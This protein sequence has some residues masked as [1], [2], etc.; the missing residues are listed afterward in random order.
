[1]SSRNCITNTRATKVSWHLVL[2][3]QVTTSWF[4][5]TNKIITC[6]TTNWRYCKSYEH[7]RRRHHSFSTDRKQQGVYR[8]HFDFVTSIGTGL[9]SATLLYVRHRLPCTTEYISSGIERLQLRKPS[10]PG[11]AVASVNR[12][13]VKQMRINS[14]RDDQG[15]TVIA[16]TGLRLS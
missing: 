5:L 15:M 16:V 12:K 8:Y 6:S 1:V 14:R 3:Q 9:P 11:T 10:N 2:P 13:F 7:C 4:F